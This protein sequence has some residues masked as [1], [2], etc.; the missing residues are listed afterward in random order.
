VDL[1]HT[2][3]VVKLTRTPPWAAQVNDKLQVVGQPN[4]FA[5]GDATDIKETK[6]RCSWGVHSQCHYACA[7]ELQSLHLLHTVNT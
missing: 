3:T 5:V 2:D 1:T 4:V 7:V 6:V